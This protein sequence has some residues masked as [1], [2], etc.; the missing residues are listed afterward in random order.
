MTGASSGFGAH[1]A[2][3]LAENGARVVV[4]AR[5]VE[6]LEDLVREIQSAGGTALAVVMDVTDSDSV[7]A[8][9]DSAE[10]A[11][12]VVNIVV[13]NAGVADPKKALAVDEDSWDFVVGPD[14]SFR[15]H[16]PVEAS[17]IRGAVARTRRGCH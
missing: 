5:R 13:N 15:R 11:L 14:S 8:A 1:F 4:A 6:R 16:R 7:S 12:G 17:G 10:A 3:V 2:R 9:F